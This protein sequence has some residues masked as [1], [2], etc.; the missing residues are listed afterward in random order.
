M[1][2]SGGA[3]SRAIN[4]DWSRVHKLIAYIAIKLWIFNDFECDKHTPNIIRGGD[5]MQHEY[6]GI[7]PCINLMH[8]SPLP[9]DFNRSRCSL[10]S[11]FILAVIS[12]LWCVWMHKHSSHIIIIDKFTYTRPISFLFVLRTAAKHVCALVHPSRPFV[13]HAKNWRKM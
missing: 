3:W 8:H 10:D 12:W 6:M 4:D 1:R 13:V 2:K 11:G 7:A 9:R 5:N